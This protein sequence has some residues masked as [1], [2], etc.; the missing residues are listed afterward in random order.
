MLR[1]LEP[2][3]WYGG[4]KG[5]RSFRYCFNVYAHACPT[6]LGCPS[7]NFCQLEPLLAQ[8]GRQNHS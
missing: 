1:H 3:Y 4:E 6:Y 5:A 2:C 8:R 7:S